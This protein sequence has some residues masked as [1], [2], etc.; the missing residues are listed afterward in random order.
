MHTEL[1]CI[2][3]KN[4]AFPSRSIGPFVFQKVV[5][6]KIKKKPHDTRQAR[7]HRD[8]TIPTLS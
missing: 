5:F 6:D 3:K 7:I 4:L 1:S 8:Y 2:Y